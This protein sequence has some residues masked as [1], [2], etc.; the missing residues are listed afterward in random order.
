MGSDIGR[1]RLEKELTGGERGI[2]KRLQSCTDR[3]RLNASG[4]Q[5]LDR[6][7]L[8]TSTTTPV[9]PTLPPWLL[10][11]YNSQW[12]IESS[13]TYPACYGRAALQ[14]S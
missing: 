1:P 10:P 3:R 2:S 7:H 5:P 13:H 8:H 14:P 4:A 12:T 6:P 9:L 11:S